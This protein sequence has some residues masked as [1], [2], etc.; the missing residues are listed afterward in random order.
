MFDDLYDL[1][2]SDEAPKAF[3]PLS[4]LEPS[5]QDEYEDPYALGPEPRENF[6][7]IDPELARR[8]I[9]AMNPE[10]RSI[11]GFAH[12]LYTDISDFAGGI[13]TLVGGALRELPHLPGDIVGAI[14]HPEA[15]AE[16]VGTIAKAVGQHYVDEYTPREGEGLLGMAGR[17]MYERPFST[18]MDLSAVLQGPA[19]AARLVGAEGA[20][21]TRAAEIGRS[22]DP[23]T[24]GG[25]IVKPIAKAAVP[26]M[27]ARFVGS[28]AAADAG[29]DLKAQWRT[30]DKQ[31]DYALHDPQ[32]G[33]FAGL[34][35]A[36]KNLLFAYG[37]GR[38]QL[39]PGAAEDV[40]IPTSL[41]GDL[42][43]RKDAM[44]AAL[45]KYDRVQT[46]WDRRRGVLPEQ[47]AEM[48]LATNKRE[49]VEAGLDPEAPEH[50][51]WLEAN[52]Q[53]AAQEA[54]E[55]F[56]LRRTVSM[57]TLLDESRQ[58]EWQQAINR[59]ILEGRA[60]DAKEAAELIPRPVQATPAEAME[61][62]GPDGGHIFPH[63][64]EVLTRDQ[65][66]VGAIL[67]KLREA[68][69]WK[70]N[71][72]EM[73]KLGLLHDYD[74]ERAMWSAHAQISRGNT[75]PMVAQRLVEELK[76]EGMA[77]ELPR[78]YKMLAD[79]DFIKGTHQFISPGFLHL[80]DLMRG[81]YHKFLA[82]VLEVG[83]DAAVKELNIPELTERFLQGQSDMFKLKP[84]FQGKVYKIPKGAA[85]SYASYERSLRPNPSVVSQ[86]SDKLLGP[87]HWFNLRMAGTKLSNDAI[88][89]TLSGLIQGV[90]PF[91]LDGIDAIRAAGAAMRGRFEGATPLQQKLAKVY[92]FPGVAQGAANVLMEG[93]Y[94]MG[95]SMGWFS[96]WLENSPWAVTRGL[97]KWGRWTGQLN[98][99]ID[100][101]WRAASTIY[102]LK[103]TAPEGMKGMAF[104]TKA[105]EDF[106]DHI[107]SMGK[108]GHE[109]INEAE[110]NHAL[111]A[112]NN[113]FPNF[114][115]TTATERQVLR[116]FMPYNRFYKFAA[117][118]LLK[119]PFQHPLKGQIAK[120]LGQYAQKEVKD[121]LAGWG[122][123]WN[124]MV[125]ENLRTGVPV[126][127][128]RGPDGSPTVMMLNAQGPNPFSFLTSSDLGE[129]GLGAV[130][131]F[132]RMA[133]EHVTGVNLYT[134]RKFIGPYSEAA[135]RIPDPVTGELVERKTAPPLLEHFL[136]QFRIYNTVRDMAAQGR[137]PTDTATLLDMIEGSDNAWELDDR[138]FARRKPQAYGPLTPL[139]RQFGL[140]PQTLQAPS[141]RQLTAQ[142]AQMAALFN[143][144]FQRNPSMQTKMLELV[145]KYSDEIMNEEPPVPIQPR[146]F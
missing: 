27:V 18:L 62:M 32:E 136:K 122:Y 106:A 73:F 64:M 118:L 14:A 93:E 121:V 58:S 143:D 21:L 102:E 139:I 82:R 77:Q 1:G 116:H 86:I 80:R 75:L 132:L 48:R 19:G 50:K 92:D 124:T 89:N 119:F 123:D 129:A 3:E 97:G 104:S 140:T 146:L 9:F 84:E 130:N 61:L 23:L 126:D 59:E 103:K 98:E 79:E 141:T 113:Y 71:T 5:D 127:M 10:G 83:D 70:D 53:Q 11:E 39:L 34:N 68:S 134:N 44:D 20:A 137:K 63:S 72:G 6:S 55:Q 49:L 145:Q 91:S 2:G 131:P 94:G 109:L 15:T 114:D 38:F 54:Q 88:G 46:E 67:S 107:D 81:E 29:A 90:H 24:L 87:W 52:A 76:P 112:V 144:I 66:T 36:E 47:V 37:E 111:K 105:L 57:R 26:D 133:W 60:K 51:A 78:G 99:Q 108:M 43:L 69:I 100:D 4:F 35:Q 22:L 96:D 128:Q 138:G 40:G 25:N 28:R 117:N 56:A 30:L 13:Q 42:P 31:F 33:V 85:D 101:F 120:N 16:K 12:N 41:P 125:P 7:H 8:V 17:K 142:R 45:Q 95:K 74:L 110:Y 135:G 115:R 65:S